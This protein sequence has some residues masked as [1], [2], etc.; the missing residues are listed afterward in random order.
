MK[1]S[2]TYPQPQVASQYLDGEWTRRPS[3]LPTA[4]VVWYGEQPLGITPLS[5]SRG[6]TQDLPCGKPVAYHKA[7]GAA[8]G[9]D[10]SHPGP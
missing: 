6:R 2:T 9:V 8:S 1:T 7:T 3:P 4:M 10:I 5:E